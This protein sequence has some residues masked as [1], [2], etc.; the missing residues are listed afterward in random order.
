MS[1]NSYSALAAFVLLTTVVT[2]ARAQFDPPIFETNNGAVQ[3]QIQYTLF[4]RKPYYAFK[5]IPYA[6][7]PIGQLRFKVFAHQIFYFPN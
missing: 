2:V 7:P 3:G 6:M 5:G 1:I 4:D